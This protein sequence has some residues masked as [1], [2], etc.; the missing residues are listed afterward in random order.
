MGQFPHTSW[1]AICCCLDIKADY[2]SPA[3]R[4]A[5]TQ[6][7]VNEKL[8]EKGIM[9]KRTWAADH[10]LDYDEEQTR[11]AAEPKPP[12]PIVQP[13]PVANQP[14]SESRIQ[15][16]ANHALEMARVIVPNIN[17]SVPPAEVSVNVPEQPTPSVTVN[18]PEQPTPTVTVNVPEQ[19]A[20]NVTVAA[21][22]VT[23]EPASVHV[24]VPEM[25]ATVVPAPIVN[26]NVP[27][28]PDMDVELERDAAGMVKKMRRTKRKG[29]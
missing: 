2:S 7:Q 20:P 28:P 24:T 1:K 16:L 12:I 5:A 14:Y 11:I 9:S 29:K 8:H 22:N 3:S 6:T 21:P 18:I 27:D 17:V 4:D 13:M 25:P 23:I 15:E 10:G 19:P 26:V